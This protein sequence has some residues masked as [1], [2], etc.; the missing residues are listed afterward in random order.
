MMMNKF[1]HTRSLPL[2]KGLQVSQFEAAVQRLASFTAKNIIQ[3][4]SDEAGTLLAR[5]AKHVALELQKD[6]PIIATAIRYADYFPITDT[7]YLQK[8]LTRISPDQLPALIVFAFTYRPSADPKK[9]AALLNELDA[10]AVQLLPNMDLNTILRTLYAFL[11][12]MPNWIMRIDFY[13]AAMQRVTSH[14]ILVALTKEKFVQI[15]FYLGLEKNRKENA[16]LFQELLSRYLEL[17]LP[18]LSTLDLVM[19]GNAAF[20][21]STYVDSKAYNQRLIDEVLKLSFNESSNDV[22]L[23]TL[24]KAMRL[25]RVHS[26]EVCK[27][28]TA[29]CNEIF[30]ERFQIRGCVHIFAYLADNLWDERNAL[31]CLV[32]HCLPRLRR[33]NA[34]CK[35]IATFLWCCAQLN[36]NLS[37]KDLEQ[38]EILLINKVNQNEF[39]NFVDQ[40][41]DS[42]LSLWILGNRSR[43]LLETVI[44][45]KM[46]SL[47]NNKNKQCE[48][49]KVESRFQVLTSAIAI[50]EPTWRFKNIK[51]PTKPK[52]DTIAPSYLLKDRNNLV[53]L[54]RKIEEY[55][56]VASAKLVCP[57]NGIN[58]PSVLV[59]FNE[60]TN[61]NMFLELLPEDLE[62][63]FSKTPNGL[64][65]L[66]IRL[67]KV[68]RY[69]VTTLPEK[70]YE[71][72]GD[73]GYLVCNSGGDT[74]PKLQSLK[75]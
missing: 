43:V 48:Q 21:T 47:C 46:S 68:L 44:D 64:M 55:S 16:G 37:Q 30:L 45:L 41:V 25:Q 13:K 4:T 66:K 12:L 3:E 22:L 7:R 27:H 75:V 60:P 31:E 9:Y 42:C 15:C 1:F 26:E 17:Y 38:I 71:K 63:H 32:K 53:D 5:F 73:L 49:P 10:T 70:Q 65:R 74:T 6:T 11:Y 18:K 50:E 40:L 24:I 52:V 51:V 56:T 67:L 2:L 35:D 72:D 59:S 69:R 33:E 19:V 23:V 28:L 54:A 61:S 8:E 14:E 20:K 39:R 29:L 57:V 58:I 62:L 36:C 34:R